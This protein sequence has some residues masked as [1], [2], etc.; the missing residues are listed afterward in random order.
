MANITNDLNALSKSAVGKE[1]R[2]PMKNSLSAINNG[3]ENIKSEL[4]SMEDVLSRISVPYKVKM[5]GPFELYLAE[6][7]YRARNSS[8]PNTYLSDTDIFIEF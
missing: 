5:G 8:Y 3:N 6:Y 7:G 1:A 4:T 2:A